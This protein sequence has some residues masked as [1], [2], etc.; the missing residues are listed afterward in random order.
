MLREIG[1]PPM[2]VLPRLIAAVLAFPPWVSPSNSAGV[3]LL[4]AGGKTIAVCMVDSSML[5]TDVCE[6]IKAEVVR[7]CGLSAWKILISAAP[8][9][10]ARGLSAIGSAT[11]GKPSGPTFAR[12]RRTRP[13]TS[14]LS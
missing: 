11:K 6:A 3:A 7:Q 2:K 13:Q 14:F 1:C 8:S 9:S 10:G 12:L 5:P 4:E